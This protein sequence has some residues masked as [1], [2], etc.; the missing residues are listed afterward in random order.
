[1]SEPSIKD[2]TA[3]PNSNLK[4]STSDSNNTNEITITEDSKN[5]SK[6]TNKTV[7]KLKETNMFSWKRIKDS[8]TDFFTSQTEIY[9]NV[10]TTLHNFEVNK[11]MLKKTKRIQS[12]YER[13]E[14]ATQ[15]IE[16]RKSQS[17]F[18]Q[19]FDSKE[20]NEEFRISLYPGMILSN[21]D[22]GFF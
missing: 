12:M 16:K 15:G 4:K 22:F 21:F 8:T 19:N 20:A 2:N 13:E 17:E 10:T 9:K 18:E 3:H 5:I 6:N 11:E 7:S 14:P 1:M